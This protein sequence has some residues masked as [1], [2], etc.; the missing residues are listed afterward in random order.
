MAR[1]PRRDWEVGRA[2]TW[3]VSP[4]GAER[5]AAT[6]MVD[7][8][9]P[10]GVKVWTRNVAGRTTEDGRVRVCFVAFQFHP[11]VGGAQV[12]AE[13]LARHLLAQGHEVIVL[14]LRHK[15]RW[16]RAEVLAGLPVVRAGGIYRQD[17]DLRTGRLG[18]WA[19]NVSISLQL[20]RL[21]STFDLIHVFQLSPLAAAAVFMG[22]LFRKP[23]IVR[24]QSAGPDEMQRRRLEHGAKLMPDLLIN[25]SFLQVG[26]NDWVTSGDLSH[27]PHAALGGHVLLRCLR[28]SN[29][30]YQALSIRCASTLVAQGFRPDRVVRIPGSVD[31]DVFRPAHE[32]RPSPN[33]P[34]RDIICVARLA[35]PKGVDV[36]IH[37]W[38]RLLRSPARWRA[39]VKPRLLIV[40]DGPDR[41]QLE[42]I[43]VELGIDNDLK[44]L[45][46]RHDTVDLLQGCWGFVLPSRWEGMP[47]ALLEAMACGLPCV[48][49]CVS[50]SEDIITD[51]VNGLLVEP[52]DPVGLAEALRRIVEDSDL[53]QQ[54]A[55]EARKTVVHRYQLDRMIDRYVALYRYVCQ[56]EQRTVAAIGGE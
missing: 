21:R 16:P 26:R 50:G 29:A 13:K 41:P 40:G 9:V 15:H 18:I 38:G 56:T 6:E 11:M 54:L 20:W 24:I 49:T 17:G 44:F 35:F 53:A 55:Q 4:C 42:R 51:G 22:K 5:K 32:R 19:A 10:A 43:A 3:K 37:A 23:A 33:Q 47:N 46:L 2:T 25:T 31:T 30:Y 12:Q 8:A 7:A 48:A 45:G 1:V 39:D 27:M 52:E 36:L 34:G 28:S 14:T